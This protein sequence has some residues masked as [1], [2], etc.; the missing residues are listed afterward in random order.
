VGTLLLFFGRSEPPKDLLLCAKHLR[1]EAMPM[2][3]LNRRRSGR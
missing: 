2:V 1:I 3:P